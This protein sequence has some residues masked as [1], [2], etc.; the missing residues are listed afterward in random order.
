MPTSDNSSDWCMLIRDKVQMSFDLSLANHLFEVGRRQFSL[1]SPLV[2]T[3]LCSPLTFQSFPIW[4]P[5][6]SLSC[7][8]NYPGTCIFHCLVTPQTITWPCPGRQVSDRSVKTRTRQF[9]ALCEIFC[10]F[11]DVWNDL[12]RG[13]EN[14]QSCDLAEKLRSTPQAF[15]ALCRIQASGILATN[16]RL[17]P[18]CWRNTSFNFAS[19]LSPFFN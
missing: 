15:L 14:S 4:P 1:C 7:P 8:S 12:K 16:A 11:K 5:T 18:S 3:F 13:E 9:P 2:S 17:S 6:I 10:R 19:K